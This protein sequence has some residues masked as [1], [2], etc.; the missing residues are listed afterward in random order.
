MGPWKTILAE[1][2]YIGLPYYE[3]I[4][5]VVVIVNMYSIKHFKSEWLDIMKMDYSIVTWKIPD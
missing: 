1:Q 2:N 4:I 5:F 3:G